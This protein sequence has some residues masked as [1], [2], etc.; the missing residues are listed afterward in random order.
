MIGRL[1][2]LNHPLPSHFT[3][4]IICRFNHRNV[5][6]T[7]QLIWAVHQNFCCLLFNTACVPSPSYKARHF[8]KQTLE[9]CALV[10][11]FMHLSYR[12]AMLKG[13]Q[14]NFGWD[15]SRYLF[16]KPAGVSAFA[17]LCYNVIPSII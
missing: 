12:H 1:T 7:R 13:R 5:I 16:S 11:I 2:C 10:K 8:F 3:S 6:L 9:L 15:C 17:D 4:H 14:K